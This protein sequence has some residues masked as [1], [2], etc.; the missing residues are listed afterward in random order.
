MILVRAL[1]AGSWGNRLRVAMETQTDA[2]LITTVRQVVGATSLRLHSAVG[3]EAGSELIVTDATNTD[4]PIKVQSIDRQNDYLITLE[5]ST[6]LPGLVT[7]GDQVRSREYRFV[8]ELL[9]QPDPGNPSR[10]NQVIDREVF[11]NLSLDFRHS[12]YFQRVMG[13]TWDMANPTVTVDDTVPVGAPAAPVR[14][15]LRG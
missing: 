3:V 2:L 11:A 13:C 8:V 6:P 7:A 4:T 5:A 14:Q 10:N 9:R 12:R 15:T 1:D